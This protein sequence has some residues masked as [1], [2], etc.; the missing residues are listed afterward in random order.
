[1]KLTGKDMLE[2]YQ[3]LARTAALNL[4]VAK[5]RSEV[6]GACLLG[7]RQEAVSIVPMYALYKKGILMESLV[8]GDHRTQWGCAVAKD[9][10]TAKRE[11]HHHATEILRNH[12]NRATGGNRGRDSNIH[13]GCLECRMLQFMYS[14]M[15]GMVGTAI[16]YGQEIFRMEWA[17]LLPEKRPIAIAFYGEG[18]EQQGCIHEARNWIGA[19]NYKWDIDEFIKRYGEE[20]VTPLM[21][22]LKVVNGAPVILVIVKNRYS[23]LTDA[24]EEYG[25]ANLVDR[26]LGYGDIIGV[27][28]NSDDIISYYNACD[29]AIANAQHCVSTLMV[30][31]TY[32]GTGHN[33]DQIKYAGPINTRED[34]ANVESVFGVRDMAEFYAAWKK[35]P[36]LFPHFLLDTEAVDE[37]TAKAIRDDEEKAMLALAEEV[38]AERA[39]TVEEDKK[40]RS[41]FPPVNWGAPPKEPDF[42]SGDSLLLIK[43]GY[44]RTYARVIGNLMRKDSRVIYF[45]EDVASKEGGVLGLTR[46]LI[47]EFG[48]HRIRSTPISEEIMQ[49]AGGGMAL[50]GSKPIIEGQFGWFLKE[51]M[52]FLEVEGMMYYQK[53][54][55]FGTVTIFPSGIVHSG[56][57]GA[58]HEYYSEGHLCIMD[59]VTTLFPSNA[60]D[61][62][63]F[64]YATRYYE[65]P[66]A[67]ILEISAGNSSE[68]INFAMNYATGELDPNVPF[69]VPAEEYVIPFGKAKIVRAGKDFTVVAYGAAAVSAAKNEADFMAKGEGIDAEVIDLRT[70]HPADFET[71]RASVQK[72]GRL[73]IMQAASRATGAGRYLKS[74]LLEDE[75]CMEYLLDPRGIKIVAAGEEGDL[76]IPTAEKLLWARLPYYKTEVKMKDEK[77]RDVA[78]TIHRSEKL[79]RAIREGM[80]YR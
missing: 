31:D 16:G 66:V 45:G 22:E 25:M 75:G 14:D 15:G 24:I 68:F 51:A 10:L 40:D 4:A 77:G 76:F 37:Q 6:F 33:Q 13:L 49:Q 54:M 52:K 34:L 73:A 67:V 32:R 36:I 64:L 60:Y 63:G 7:I 46:G 74:E 28:V 56:G 70:V 1:M 20:F 44:N 5:N 30:V 19:S 65:G 42:T 12:F 71:I 39:I 27:E 72:T 58:F 78:P 35:D 57:S 48:P 61:L 9:I 2:L 3:W 59:G 11:G 18:A 17:G 55:R 53:K 43:E 8:S 21:R 38:L 50:Y 80:R 69:G 47:A 26:A 41:I 29:E 23:L 79:A 62:A